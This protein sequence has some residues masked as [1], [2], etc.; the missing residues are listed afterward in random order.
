MQRGGRSDRFP[1]SRAGAVRGAPARRRVRRGVRRGPVDLLGPARRRSGRGAVLGTGAG[2]RHPGGRRA[3]PPASPTPPISP[4]PGCCGRPRPPR[5]WPGAAAV[6][7]R[8]WPSGRWR[9]SARSPTGR[10]RRV[11]P[12]GSKARHPRAAAPGRRGRPGRPGDAISQVQAGCGRSRRRVLIANSDGL[13]AG[14]EQARTR[15][16]VS[17]VATGDTG[18]QTGYESA[19]RTARVRAVRRGV[20]GGAGRAG[21]RPGPV[22]AVRPPGPLG[23]AA[24]GAGRGQRRHPLPRGLRPRA[25]GRP[26]REGR[27][28]LHRHGRA[29]GGQPAGHPGRRRHRRVG[30]G[31]VR[32][33][34]RGP[35]GPAQRAHRQRGADRL[36]VGLPAGPQGGAGRRRA[37]AGARPTSTCPWCG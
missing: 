12:A 17:C 37:T 36:P 1:S 31:D 34:R 13:L 2:G 35:A 28:G 6:A 24:G 22:Q 15:F 14:D 11:R 19:A 5:P 27:L 9:G 8:R 18:L 26:H 3:R 4:R 29:A 20:G 30:V 21:R 10:R 32:R 25:R 7:R 23:R 33:R 16:C